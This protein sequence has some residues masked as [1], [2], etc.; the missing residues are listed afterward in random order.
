MAEFEKRLPMWNAPGIEPPLDKTD[1]G[2]KKSERPPAEYMNFLHTTT[3]EALKELQESAVHVEGE[4][5]QEINNGMV[6][7]SDRVTFQRYYVNV[8]EFGAVGDGINDDTNAF[9]AAANYARLNNFS[10]FVPQSVGSYIISDTVDL[11][12][13]REVK[14]NGTINSRVAGA[15]TLLVGGDSSNTLP[16]VA[17][18]ARLV[19]SNPSRNDI[20]VRVTGV[21]NG[22]ITIM[23]DYYTQVYVNETISNQGSVSYS[24]FFMGEV[25]RLEFYGEPDTSSWITDCNIYGGRYKEIIIGHPGGL[26][27]HNNLIF[28]KPCVENL[29][30]KIEIF[31][32]NRCIFNGIRS[33]GGTKYYFYEKSR[34]NVIIDNYIPSSQFISGWGTVGLDLGMENIV[35]SPMQQNMIRVPV[36]RFDANTPLY[37]IDSPQKL[38][39]I[40]F[41]KQQDKLRL[42]TSKYITTLELDPSK[43]RRVGFLSDSEYF[44]PEFQVQDEFGLPIDDPTAIAGS[45]SVWDPAK[46][47]QTYLTGTSS[48]EMAYDKNG[49]K[50]IKYRLRTSGSAGGNFA[51]YVV[52]YLEVKRENLDYAFRVADSLKDKFFRFKGTTPPT[53]GSWKKGEVYWNSN[54]NAGGYCAWV[55]VASGTP[56]IWNEWGQIKS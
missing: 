53:S 51:Q 20:G 22:K 14:I 2:W 25:D 32:G 21:K 16:C 29:N 7:L 27:R 43:V 15:P 3:F 54:P 50:K 31:N 52:V 19:R 56:G 40:A 5:M 24:D 23:K 33:E 6:D 30:S 12:G 39:E 48:K 26:F 46:K 42:F 37:G 44:I 4:K 36:F 17:Y 18:I 13:I 10:L 45:G 49:A 38:D 11:L 1:E 47:M 8:K 9:K 34:H 41:E 28:Y 35:I 55:C